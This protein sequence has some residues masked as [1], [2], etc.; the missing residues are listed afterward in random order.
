MIEQLNKQLEAAKDKKR[1][2]QKWEAQ[3]Q[4]YRQ[5]LEIKKG[6]AARQ[7][8]QL[9][10]EE[11]DVNKLTGMSLQN[12]VAAISGSK[13]ERLEKEQQEAIA[14]RVKY[15]EATL[16]VKEI[17]EE[18]E[19]LASI[20]ESVKQAELDVQTVLEEIEEA[21][22]DSNSPLTEEL[23]SINDQAAEF[24]ALQ[25][26]ISEAVTA[27]ENVMSSLGFAEESL[28]KAKNWG[29]FDLLG[30]GL[31]STAVKHNHINDARD[32]I[33]AAQKDMRIFQKE[34]ID[35]N[36]ELHLS[37]DISGLLTFADYFFD[38]FF[39]DLLVQGKINKALDEIEEQKDKVGRL[40]GDLGTLKQNVEKDL[41]DLESQ[42][43]DLLEGSV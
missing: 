31:L 16:A 43:V 2:K 9:E 8:K 25:T 1:H 41:K 22:T 29:T 3:L 32:T 23:H 13:Q 15:D 19:Q 17:E 10:K 6:D 24:K 11:E 36:Q 34:L 21:I 28:Y 39:S 12:L 7:R 38:D 30:G 4:S 14:A 27:G 26:E 35:I 20:L 42:R 33:H 5:E 18:I 37:I 40:L